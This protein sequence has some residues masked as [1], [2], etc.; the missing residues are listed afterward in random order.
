MTPTIRGPGDASVGRAR[1][2]DVAVFRNGGGFFFHRGV[3]NTLTSSRNCNPGTIKV[4]S[5]DQV[6]RNRCTP[7]VPRLTTRGVPTP[8][9]SSSRRVAARDATNATRTGV[10]DAR[11]PS[12]ARVA[13]RPRAVLCAVP[14]RLA[15]ASS[16]TARSVVAGARVRRRVRAFER[17]SRG[18]NSE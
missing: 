16:R 6:V 10:R 15:F 5:R 7:K 14:V 2:G 12:R 1:D 18:S 8:R 17:A 13:R 3:E 4:Q 11:R 9:P